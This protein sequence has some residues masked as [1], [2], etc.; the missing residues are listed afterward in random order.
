MWFGAALTGLGAAALVGLLVADVQR[1]W[2]LALF[3]PFWAGAI[4]L[5]QA[6]EKT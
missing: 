1:G 3:L 4:G 5:L 2:R 6:M